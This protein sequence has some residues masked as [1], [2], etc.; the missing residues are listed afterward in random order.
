MSEDLLPELVDSKVFFILHLSDGFGHVKLDEESSHLTTFTIPFSLYR[1]KVLPFEI[2]PAPKI[3]QKA[4]YGNNSDQEGVLNKTNDILVFGRGKRIEE[5]TALT[6]MLGTGN[7]SKPPQSEPVINFC[8]LHRAY[9]K[10][11]GYTLI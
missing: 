8:V 10:V 2:I 5:A 11:K 7:M 6:K 3:F 4:V 9:N 1:W